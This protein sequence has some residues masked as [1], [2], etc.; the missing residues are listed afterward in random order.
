[1]V[2]SK[3]Q[4]GRH[5]CGRMGRRPTTIR[6]VNDETL[7]HRSWTSQ[8]R[9]E[10]PSSLNECLAT[11]GSYGFSFVFTAAVQGKLSMGS[12]EIS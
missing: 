11:C 6:L 5:L 12:F 10:N 8:S 4:T 3:Q 7:W 2:A 9:L 1:M